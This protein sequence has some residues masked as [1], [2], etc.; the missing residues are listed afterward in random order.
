MK[1]AIFLLTL[2][3]GNGVIAQNPYLAIP[4]RNL[5]F[6]ELPYSYD[7]IEPVIDRLT[8]EIHY[9]K[10]HKAYFDN[11][12]KTIANT[13]LEEK[14]LLQLFSEM[15][16]YSD[17][18]RNN[19]GGYY[20]HILYWEILKPGNKRNISEKL[21]FAINRD[22]GSMD[23]L[24]RQLVDASLKQFGSGWSWLS[25]DSDG[26]LF[27]SSTQNQDNPL[28]NIVKKQGFPIIGIDV[29]EHAYYLKYQNKRAEYVNLIWEDINWE[30]VSDLY[31]GIK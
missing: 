28:M 7:A 1:T 5:S 31:N 26:K 2:I 9:S 25:V 30:T 21:K 14:T 11:F 4:S 16:N 24:K 18:V 12:K 8:V 10:H 3:I 27:V 20:N 29:W 23:E 13:E 22:F 15:S 6:Y 19:S 17:L